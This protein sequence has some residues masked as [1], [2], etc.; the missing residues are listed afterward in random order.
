MLNDTVTGSELVTILSSVTKENIP[1][2]LWDLLPSSVAGEQWR[3]EI[4]AGAYTLAQWIDDSRSY[5]LEDLQDLTGQIANSECEDYYSNIN[6]RVQEL[7]LWADSDL[8]DE[9][10][11]LV[12]TDE[13]ATLTGLNSLYLY[14]AMRR[15]DMAL[16]Q[17]AIDTAQDQESVA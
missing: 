3:G 16:A 12:S 4:I 14:A 9:V 8:D 7:S 6:T 10:A 5:S 1:A 13:P 2:S 11:Q 17:W 15:L